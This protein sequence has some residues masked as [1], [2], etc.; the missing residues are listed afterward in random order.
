M[1]GVFAPSEALDLPEGTDP[2]ADAVYA[3]AA[4]NFEK[5]KLEAPLHVE[6]EPSLYVYRLRMGSHEQTGVAAC[7]SLAEYDAD[8]VRKIW[9]GPRGLDGRFLWYGPALGADL[10][11]TAKTGGSPLTG[12]PF[13]ISLDWVPLDQYLAEYLVEPSSKATVLASSFAATLELVREGHLELNQHAA[14]APRY[15]RKRQQTG[16]GGV[17]AETGNG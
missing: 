16:E 2:H 6:G 4:E 12:Q 17:A 7:C 5:L 8:V 13:G 1:N 15:V 3:K 9:E 10:S 14:F 11:A